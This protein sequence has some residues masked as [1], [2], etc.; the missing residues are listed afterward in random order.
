MHQGP[1]MVSSVSW[2]ASMISNFGLHALQLNSE[3]KRLITQ[4][5]TKEYKHNQTSQ[6]ELLLFKVVNPPYE[7]CVIDSRRMVK[8]SYDYM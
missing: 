4:D 7:V 2:S 1:V 5:A 8:V 3:T 6:Y